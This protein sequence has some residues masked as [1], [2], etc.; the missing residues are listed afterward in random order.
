MND[1]QLRDK[2]GHTVEEVLEG[3]GSTLAIDDVGLWDVVSVGWQG[4]GLKGDG[5]SDFVR[6]A[7]VALA[8]HGAKPVVVVA[9]ALPWWV[10]REGVNPAFP[11]R[12]THEWRSLD[13]GDTSEQIADGIMA[14]ARI[15]E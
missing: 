15:Q 9:V 5:L 3:I 11:E 10:H 14:D 2:D 8:E 1:D 13:C 6:G 7:I 12:A 4:F